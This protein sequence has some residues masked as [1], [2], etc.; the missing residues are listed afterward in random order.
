MGSSEFNF[1]TYLIWC[2]YKYLNPAKETNSP[3]LRSSSWEGG[4][5]DF[6][7]REAA[8]INA[9]SQWLQEQNGRCAELWPELLPCEAHLALRF[10]GFFF[11]SVKNYFAVLRVRAFTL[12]LF[13]T[14]ALLS[15]QGKHWAC[16]W[17]SRS[18]AHN[19]G[20]SPKWQMLVLLKQIKPKFKL[21]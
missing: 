1:L 21:Q 8:T 14:I 10:L 7:G 19:Q 9:L 18:L 13:C 5:K 15:F 20:P 11:P 2:R 4:R 3:F 12:N 16:E 17:N 6:A